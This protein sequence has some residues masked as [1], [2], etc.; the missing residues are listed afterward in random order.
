M[1]S[2]FRDLPSAVVLSSA[3]SDADKT[4]LPQS[5]PYPLS[6]LQRNAPCVKSIGDI[7]PQKCSRAGCLTCSSR[8][9]S[10]RQKKRCADGAKIQ[11]SAELRLL[12]ALP[13][14]RVQ[15]PAER[16]YA[17]QFGHNQ[18]P[19]L[20]PGFRGEARQKAA[21][22]VLSDLRR[23]QWRTGIVNRV[24]ATHGTPGFASGWQPSLF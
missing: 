8:N 19:T 17:V 13:C 21:E 15:D 9:P 20:R 6:R 12:L 10:V 18:M 3:V 7:C 5:K 4:S 24:A 2:C 14:V 23:Q 22:Y 16:A 11:R 1:V